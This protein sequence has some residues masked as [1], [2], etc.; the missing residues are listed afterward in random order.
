MK[1]RLYNGIIIT[2]PNEVHR[3]KPRETTY[4]ILCRETRRGQH[5]KKP[6][7]QCFEI[8]HLKRKKI[9]PTLENND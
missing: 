2:Q 1:Y 9:N 5:K 7:L 4:E 8:T 3:E 6:I